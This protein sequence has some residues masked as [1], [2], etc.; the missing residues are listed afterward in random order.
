MSGSGVYK[1]CRDAFPRHERLACCA[2]MHISLFLSA[3]ASTSD[4]AAERSL[5]SSLAVKN[6]QWAAQANAS[7]SGYDGYGFS[8]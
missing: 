3:A 6:G 1:G 7:D 8:G 5:S 2:H 4:A